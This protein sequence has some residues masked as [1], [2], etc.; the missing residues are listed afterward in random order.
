MANFSFIDTQE[1]L[2]WLRDVHG[3]DITGIVAAEIHGNED[4]PE[5]VCTYKRNDYQERPTTWLRDENG[6]LKVQ[7]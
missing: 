1:D 5:R 3:V 7:S 6:N 2:N 4:C